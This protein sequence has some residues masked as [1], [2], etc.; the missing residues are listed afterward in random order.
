MFASSLRAILIHVPWSSEATKRWE[1]IETT[2]VSTAVALTSVEPFSAS[3]FD[4]IEYGNGEEGFVFCF[5]AGGFCG[6]GVGLGVAV[7]GL[8]V[9]AMV[10]RPV[11]VGCLGLAEVYFGGEGG[12]GNMAS[13]GLLCLCDF[14][15]LEVPRSFVLI[16]QSLNS[17][18]SFF[19][20]PILCFTLI[21]NSLFISNFFICLNVQ[22][23]INSL[24]PFL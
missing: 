10:L 4:A 19:P 2:G 8:L 16:S 11:V 7:G 14:F 21:L 3:T 15:L 23:F 9:P 22:G 1:A 20:N 24:F 17:F 13:G 5:L 12:L 6:E 18:C